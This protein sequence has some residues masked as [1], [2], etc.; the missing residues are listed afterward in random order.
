VKQLFLVHGEYPVQ[1]D[2]KKRLLRKG[3]RDVEM[4]EQHQSF[5]LE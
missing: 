1:Q 5:T 4:P 2:F 3:F